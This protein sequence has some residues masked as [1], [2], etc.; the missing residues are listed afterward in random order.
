METGKER[1]YKSEKYDSMFIHKLH[2]KFIRMSQ[3]EKREKKIGVKGGIY[4][5]PI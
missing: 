5:E 3:K 4:D 2:V 1:L